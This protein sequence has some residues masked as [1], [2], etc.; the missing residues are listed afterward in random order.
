MTYRVLHLRQFVDSTIP[1]CR[2][3]ATPRFTQRAYWPLRNPTTRTQT[4]PAL[5]PHFLPFPA[6]SASRPVSL[7]DIVW[8]LQAALART[9]ARRPSATMIRAIYSRRIAIMSALITR[10]TPNLTAELYSERC[11]KCM[12]ELIVDSLVGGAGRSNS[13]AKVCEAARLKQW[14][15]RT[16][17]LLHLHPLRSRC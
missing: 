7:R 14:H 5:S 15:S 11:E 17:A 8:M 1:F 4:R 3:T 9:M 16:P 13:I 10:N 2:M 6:C 12:L